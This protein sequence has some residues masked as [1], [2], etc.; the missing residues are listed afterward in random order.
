MGQLGG[1]EFQVQNYSD[2]AELEFDVELIV[3]QPKPSPNDSF[4]RRLDK[5]DLFE[6]S[7]NS[8]ERVFNRKRF[9]ENHL[10]ISSCRFSPQL[11]S[12]F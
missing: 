12:Y 2:D 1:D 9:S 5:F 11:I 3:E 6:S 10:K 8:S 7:E 4:E